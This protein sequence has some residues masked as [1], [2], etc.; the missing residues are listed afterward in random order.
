MIT[1]NVFFKIMNEQTEMALAT[2][3]NNNSNVRIVN[4]YFNKNT[5]TII[6]T[7]FKNNKKI[8][9]FEQNSNVSFTTIPRLGFFHIKAN[10]IIEQSESTIFDFSNEFI[11]K[12]PEFKELII[13]HGNE[14][15]LFEIKIKKALVTLDLKNSE[16]IDL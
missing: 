13:N 12:I 7:S 5:N 2:S 6:F 8:K 3:F 16:T 4:F 1:K 14:L 10:G 9:E 11:N 15:I